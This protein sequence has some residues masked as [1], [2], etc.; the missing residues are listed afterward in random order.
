MRTNGRAESRVFKDPASMVFVG[1]TLGFP[2]FFRIESPRISIRWALAGVACKRRQK[3][4]ESPQSRLVAA[5]GPHA[6]GPS[7][8][9]RWATRR[10]DSRSCPFELRPKAA[11][12]KS[13]SR[14]VV[15][16][17]PPVELNERP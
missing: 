10:V 2:Q 9:E 16:K 4:Y 15:E 3:K 1:Y 5:D 7:P 8:I 17:R 12:A 14:Q 13:I 11:P 6:C